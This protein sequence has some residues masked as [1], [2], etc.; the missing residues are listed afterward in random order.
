V[1]QAPVPDVGAARGGRGILVLAGGRGRRMGREKAGLPF[2][3]RTLLEH[4][5]ARLHPLAD[6]VLVVARAG[7]ELPAL[8]PGVRRVD[9]E[10]PDRGPVAG[11][12]AGLA[13][14]ASEA[15][16]A[17]SC[18]APFVMP[19]VV[20]HLFARLGE[21]DAV[22]AEVQGRLHPLTA[23]YRRRVLPRARALLA[24]AG[25][26]S[27]TALCGRLDAVRVREDDL[28]T[29]D[30]RLD[31]LANLNTPEEWRAAE[32]RLAAGGTR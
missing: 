3:G 9:D 29:L 14:A 19:G 31:S 18:D 22:V 17:T 2:A 10:V 1:T 7:Q 15:V 26:H 25:P 6:E 5:L 28:R 20:E 21:A 24:G 27:L 13:A 30:P 23:V 11:L 32:A 12:A 16:F 4:V 8:P